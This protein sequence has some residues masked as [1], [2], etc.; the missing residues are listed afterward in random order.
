MN[1]T[2][3]SSSYILS[4]R[5]ERLFLND[6]SCKLHVWIRFS[7]ERAFSVCTVKLLLTAKDFIQMSHRYGFSPVC[8]RTWFVKSRLFVNR[9]RQTSQGYR[10]F[11]SRDLSC[12]PFSRISEDTLISWLLNI[13]NVQSSLQST[14]WLWLLSERFFTPREFKLIIFV[15]SSYVISVRTQ[16]PQKSVVLFLLFILHHI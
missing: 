3:F 1:S 10:F 7:S 6:F 5:A 4:K 9:F 11:S 13:R 15:F 8:V 14:S 12:R 16:Q 2:T